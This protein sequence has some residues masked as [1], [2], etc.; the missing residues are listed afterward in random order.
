VIEVV[1]GGLIGQA[2]GVHVLYR[3]MAMWRGMIGLVDKDDV[4][5]WGRPC[6]HNDQ[7]HEMCGA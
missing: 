5:V 4:I 1:A 2:A 7:G 6:T 3:W